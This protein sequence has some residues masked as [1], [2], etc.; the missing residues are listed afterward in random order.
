MGIESSELRRITRQ[1]K[2]QADNG[3]TITGR[4]VSRDP[5]TGLDI[6]ETVEGVRFRAR[7]ITNRAVSPDE[8]IQVTIGRGSQVPLWDAVPRG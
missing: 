7:S 6:I 8:P 5:T 3:R 1:L 2:R 4:V